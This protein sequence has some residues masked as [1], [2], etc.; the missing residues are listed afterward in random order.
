MNADIKYRFMIYNYKIKSIVHVQEQQT[1][2]N[3]LVIK[4]DSHIFLNLY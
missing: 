4:I 3:I 1:L 2:Q